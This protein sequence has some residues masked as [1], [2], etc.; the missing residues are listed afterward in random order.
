MAKTCIVR[1]NSKI[2]CNQRQPYSKGTVTKLA[3]QKLTVKRHYLFLPAAPFIFVSRYFMV[4]FRIP[5]HL[6]F[7]VSPS[8]STFHS[9][10]FS[11]ISIYS[12]SVYVPSQF[13]AAIPIPI[14]IPFIVST[15]IEMSFLI[16]T[17]VP[18]HIMTVIVTRTTITLSTAQSFTNIST[19]SSTVSIARL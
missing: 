13:S 3:K 8:H 19:S 14:N 5:S 18:F 2:S 17:V 16:F 11:S 15:S 7:S 6:Y 1:I 9:I 4:A 10:W 12:I